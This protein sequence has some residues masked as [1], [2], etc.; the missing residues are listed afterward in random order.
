[1]GKVRAALPE[2]ARQRL[3]ILAHVF[4]SAATPVKDF[5]S[6][7]ATIELLTQWP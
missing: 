7:A 4:G 2:Y 3:D 6:H 5:T 1:M